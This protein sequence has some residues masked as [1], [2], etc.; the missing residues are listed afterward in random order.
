MGV[1]K[2]YQAIEFRTLDTYEMVGGNKMRIEFRNSSP[3]PNARGQYTTEDP[4][5]IAALEKSASFNVS[6]KCIHSETSGDPTPAPRP[7][8]AAP[9]QPPADDKEPEGAADDT[10]AGNDAEG[11][12]DPNA[13]GNAGDGVT[14]VPGIATIQAAREYLVANCGATASKLPNGPA[15]KKFA[16]EK[17][18][19]F[20]DLA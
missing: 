20:V 10:G 15:V 2:I 18:I 16:A 13:G 11:K 5:V 1:R 7:K 6:Y 9:A 3:A 12:E 14:E 4:N 19:N 8:A 17:K